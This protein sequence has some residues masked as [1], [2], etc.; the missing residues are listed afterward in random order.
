MIKTTRL[1]FRN[2]E[3][4]KWQ[5]ANPK[6]NQPKLLKLLTKSIKEGFQDENYSLK[7][8]LDLQTKL[9]KSDSTSKTKLSLFL[10]SFFL[11]FFFSF[12]LSSYLFAA[13]LQNSRPLEDSR[14]IRIDLHAKYPFQP[15]MKWLYF[16]LNLKLLVMHS[17]TTI[18]TI[19]C[20]SS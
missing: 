20:K 16:L 4:E 2:L 8:A 12:L 11:S 1:K 18:V 15:L 13:A 7:S 5:L 3:S 9:E 10:L 14:A 17:R 19:K 6:P